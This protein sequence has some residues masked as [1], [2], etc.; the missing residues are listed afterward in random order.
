MQEI[1]YTDKVLEMRSA[2]VRSLLGM[3]ADDLPDSN[4]NLHSVREK[5]KHENRHA[6]AD[7]GSGENGRVPGKYAFTTMLKS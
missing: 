2:R 4:E 3:S 6:V 1:G 5:S 7:H